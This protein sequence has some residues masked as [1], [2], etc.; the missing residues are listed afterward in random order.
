[1]VLSSMM[2]ATVAGQALAANPQLMRDTHAMASQLPMYDINVLD[3][4]RGGLG[5]GLLND[6]TN[7]A[8]VIAWNFDSNF[9]FV[10]A[11]FLESLPDSSPIN[12]GEV[13]G[14]TNSA[15]GGSVWQ[16]TTH[17]YLGFDATNNFH[18]HQLEFS[19][20]DDSATGFLPGGT[21][22]GGTPINF[23]SQDMGTGNLGGDGVTFDG[24]VLGY[25]SASMDVYVG[26]TL[27]TTDDFFASALSFAGLNN[28]GGSSYNDTVLL[29]GFNPPIGGSIAGFNI[30]RLVIRAT[31]AV[32]VPAPG[33]VALFGLAGLAG[34][35]RRR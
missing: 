34:V 32:A 1:M 4:S 18:V 11:A 12:G 33:S 24:E 6:T 35:R 9:N 8:G 28:E 14:G 29:Q 22:L 2:V 31:V 13:N 30:D 17:T 5:T 16:E 3:T 20:R 19:I 26:A 7:N 15:S 23:M 21:T 25:F 10:T 27:A